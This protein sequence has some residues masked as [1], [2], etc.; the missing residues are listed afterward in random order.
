[1]K[2]YQVSIKPIELTEDGGVNL[3]RP[4]VTK[5]LYNK[6]ARMVI[7]NGELFTPKEYEQL[8]IYYNFTPDDFTPI[9]WKKKATGFIF[10]ARF[11]LQG[12][13]Q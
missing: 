9:H 7:I 6:R 12:G 3:R 5:E 4:K 2:Y 1:M 13:E 8:Q 10:G 11:Q